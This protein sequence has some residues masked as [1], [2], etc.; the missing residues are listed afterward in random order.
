VEDEEVVDAVGLAFGRLWE[1]MAVVDENEA[2]V[3]EE[4]EEG[5][6]AE[7]DEDDEEEEE[8]VLVLLFAARN[9]DGSNI[10]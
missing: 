6:G 2:E 3:T 7:E 5:G 10:C 1:E 9:L 8:V 4:E